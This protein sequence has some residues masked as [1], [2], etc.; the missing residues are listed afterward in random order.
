MAFTQ[1]WETISLSAWVWSVVSGG[2]RLATQSPHIR[3][4]ISEVH[5]S[6]VRR[7]PASG[8]TDRDHTAS[9]EAGDCPGLPP[10]LRVIL[11]PLAPRK[12]GDGSPIRNRRLLNTFFRPKRFRMGTLASVLACPIRGMGTAS[13]DLSDA[14]LHMPIA[15]QDRRH[16]RF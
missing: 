11:E 12:T 2:Y 10:V 7:P 5:S 13:L 6:A 15:S 9:H 1:R 16:L 4:H 3:L 8:T 14:Y